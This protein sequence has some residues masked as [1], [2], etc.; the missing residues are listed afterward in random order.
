MQDCLNYCKT[1]DNKN[2]NDIDR[3]LKYKE[4]IAQYI[5]DTENFPQL[6][7]SYAL[8]AGTALEDTI[9]FIL[10]HDETELLNI[11][12]YSTD[13]KDFKIQ[14]ESTITDQTNPDY[15]L[16]MQDEYQYRLNLAKELKYG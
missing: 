6:Q 16:M 4:Q 15:A 13:T 8:N 7:A 10:N 9:D 14:E 1:C 11:S 3:L 2:Q 12:S 5:P